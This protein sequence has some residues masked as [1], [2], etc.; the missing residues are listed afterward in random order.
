M[1]R[2]NLYIL[3]GLLSVLSFSCSED[4][5]QT[6]PT[7]AVAKDVIFQTTQGADVALNGIYRRMYSFGVTGDGHDDYGYKSLALKVDLMGHDMKV[8]SRGYG[9]YISDYNYTE[10]GNV[11]ETTT[12][13][14]S[15]DLN[16]DVIYNANVI[17]EE[18]DGLEGTK[19]ERDFVKGQ[20]FA[21]RANAYYWLA[22]FHAPTY[23]A[24]QNAPCV[25]L[26]LSSTEEHKP[27]ATVGEVY[28]VITSDLD[29]AIF[30]FDASNESRPAKSYIDLSV[31]HGLRARGALTMEDWGTAVD[32]AQAAKA[33]YSLMGTDAYLTGFKDVENPE[34]MWGMDIND[35]QATIYA[36]FF[37][38][39][40]PVKLSYASLG[41]QKQMP[42]YLFDTIPDTDIRKQIV[43]EPGDDEYFDFSGNPVPTYSV[44]KFIAGSTWAADYLMMRSAEMLLIEAEAAAEDGQTAVAQQALN[45]LYT[46]RNE[47]QSTSATGTDLINEI[48]LQRR[49]ELWGEGFG[50]FD[51]K[52]WQ[53]PL[54]RRDHNPSLCVVTDLPANSSDF[55]LRIPQR[56]IDANDE[57]SEADQID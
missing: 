21:L 35:E 12:T 13:D 7:D 29:S 19:S 53:I 32:H 17:L 1:K 42:Q 2:I 15:Y 33:G 28:D 56:E 3:I 45:D 8:F 4:Y 50:L 37:S 51:I 44:V 41:L 18:A 22:Q 54:D 52:R 24:D 30:Y 20:A 9:W 27:V 14:L 36:S 55:N 46:A 31:A 48:R 49:I 47:G 6:N 25:P 23:A 57:I 38:H 16:Y 10:R 26:K 11:N 34:W 43:V 39:M 40:D 5:L